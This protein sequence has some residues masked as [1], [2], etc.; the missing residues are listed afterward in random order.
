MNNNNQLYQ[1]LDPLK[2]CEI[3]GAPQN[4]HQMLHPFKSKTTPDFR[5]RKEVP[6]SVEIDKA[7]Q[8][9]N[10]P[11][12]YLKYKKNCYPCLACERPE[13]E[14]HS[15]SHKFQPNYQKGGYHTFVHQEAVIPKVRDEINNQYDINYNYVI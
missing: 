14:H 11:E 6:K 13:S 12:T 2:I 8:L 5:E 10:P 4:N 3:C 15:T 1:A 7:Y 9:I